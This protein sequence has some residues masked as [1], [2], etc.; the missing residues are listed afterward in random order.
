MQVTVPVR[1]GTTSSALPVKRLR[2]GSRRSATYTA[3]RVAP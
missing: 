1:E 3:L 2:S